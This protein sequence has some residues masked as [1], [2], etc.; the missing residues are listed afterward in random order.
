MKIGWV[1][2]IGIGLILIFGQVGQGRTD[3]GVPEVIINEVA[4]AGSSASSSDEWIELKNTTVIPTL[5]LMW[6]LILIERVNNS[7]FP[8]MDS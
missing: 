3:T 6:P 2:M 4:W 8:T 7:Q 5:L 1:G